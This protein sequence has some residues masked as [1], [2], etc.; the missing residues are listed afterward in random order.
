[1]PVMNGVET[2]K[3]IKEISTHTYVIMITAFAVEEL[4]RESLVNGAFGVLRKPI[5]FDKLFSLIEKTIFSGS[6]IQVVD[7]DEFVCKNLEDVLTQ[8][9]Y[10][11]VYARDGE[12]AVR[13]AEESRFDIL[14]LDLK[15]PP[16]YG[17]EVYTMIRRF[18]PELV[19]ILITGYLDEFKDQVKHIRKRNVYAC[20]EKPIDMNQLL[21]ILDEVEKER[22]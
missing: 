15:L 17:F 2:F 21:H 18:R 13:Q 19:V 9:G 20:L 12:T 22:K 11:V 16:L 4:I 7:D 5:D 1:M 3:K 8:K 14:L 6:L 10:Q